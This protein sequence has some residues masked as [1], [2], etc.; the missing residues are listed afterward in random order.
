MTDDLD[1][2][3]RSKVPAPDPAARDRAV[4][5]AMEAFD[6]AGEKTQAPAQGSAAAMR[7]RGVDRPSRSFLMTLARNAERALFSRPAM[8][9]A[10]A[11]LI[12]PVGG[13]VA[14]NV[15]DRPEYVPAPPN[16][17]QGQA[18]RGQ[19]RQGQAMRG[20][21]A[22]QAASPSA[23]DRLAPKPASPPPVAP[24]AEADVA[25]APQPSRSIAQQE[26][27]DMETFSRE[28]PAQAIPQAMPSPSTMPSDALPVEPQ[29][30]ETYP[31]AD[32]TG[33]VPVTEQPVST[34]SADV[35]TASYARVRRAILG[36]QMPP[37]DMVRTEEMV[38]YFD[39]AYPLPETRD[40]PFRATTTIVPSPWNQKAK[41][42]HIGIQGF[43]IVPETRPKA[44]LV[45]LIDT[46]GSMADADKLP[47]LIQSFQLLLTRLAPDDTVSIVTYAGSAG[48]ALE[49]TKVSE[50]DKITAALT[51]MMAGGSTAGAA[52][53]ETAYDLAKRNFVEGGVNRV[54]LATDGDFNVGLDDPAQLE[55]FIA[56]KRK[57]GIFLSVLGFGTGNLRDDMM[58]SLAQNGN[59]T[60]AYIDTLAEA[61]KV[62]VEEA[63]STLF[64]IA[65]DVKLQVE[66]NPSQV[67]EYRL[68][69]YETRMLKREDFND[70]RK[71]A[72][73]IGSGHSVTA[74]YEYLPSGVASGTV[75]PL[76]YGEKETAAPAKPSGEI[77]FL[78]MRYKLPDEDTSKLV[79]APVTPEQEVALDAAS[80]D[81]RFSIAVAAFAQKLKGNRWLGDMSYE[82]I[83]DL[84]AG[85]R[86]EDA[87]GYRNGLL[88]LVRLTEALAASAKPA[89]AM[90]KE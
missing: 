14:W 41:L 83:A 12:L 72:G 85:A 23:Q 11:L 40:V 4:L 58:Q 54:L 55:D 90:P 51:A 75:D 21:A 35:D 10:L 81:T 5:A 45:F 8:A 78:K 47:L 37:A 43:D 60:A 3:R 28:A 84:A 44:N 88:Q 59:G 67:S 64:P 74:I 49:P 69:G 76:R 77:A 33:F 9:T 39:Y 18:T 29:Q 57:T 19:A 15:L 7:P 25:A 48:V 71:D 13:Y 65:K 61:R 87:F 86:G 16:A 32:A 68:I 79:T 2:L 36:G 70:D 62:L 6:A 24:P 56:R 50:R 89:T 27:S 1:I 20:E 82:R 80:Q 46:S 66:F 53:I 42:L 17:M 34:F 38:N 63:G 52:G 30:V 26:A 31:Q 22:K 73:D